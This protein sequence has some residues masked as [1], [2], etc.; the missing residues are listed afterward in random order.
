MACLN[1]YKSREEN[2]QYCGTCGDNLVNGEN[3]KHTINI[4]LSLLAAEIFVILIWLA[5]QKLVAPV[6]FR[7]AAGNIDYNTIGPIYNVL[8]WI[9][10]SAMVVITLIC[11][12]LVKNKNARILLVVYFVIRIIVMV[13]YRIFNEY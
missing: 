5:A 2:Q 10:D 9:T 4:L 6:L 7:D 11:M 12:L 13:V 1:C 8:G 3:P